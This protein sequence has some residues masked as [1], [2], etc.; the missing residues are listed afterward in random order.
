M[1]TQ[2][3]YPFFLLRILAILLIWQTAAYAQ[4]QKTHWATDG[5]QYY[6]VQ[7]GQLV[8]LDTRDSSKKTIVLTS[9]MLT[10]SGKE[11]L[12]VANFSFSDD[13]KKILIF[14][15]TKRVWR[16]N[17]KGDYWVY[18]LSQKRLNKLAQPGRHLH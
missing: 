1:L 16:Y 4:R 3:K 12:A 2:F 15:N 8:E 10:P 5:Y 17:T 14:T 18:D 9:A 11:P 13:G 7:A 6:R